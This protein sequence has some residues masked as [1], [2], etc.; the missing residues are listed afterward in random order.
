MQTTEERIYRTHV[1][2]EDTESE[3]PGEARVVIS[4]ALAK[5]IRLL[6]DTLKTVQAMSIRDRSDGDC[7]AFG[8]ELDGDGEPWEAARTEMVVSAEYVWFEAT[9]P[10]ISDHVLANDPLAIDAIMQDFGI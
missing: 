4:L 2:S 7:A 6:S 5:R 9:I 3:L 10:E 8:D 1:D